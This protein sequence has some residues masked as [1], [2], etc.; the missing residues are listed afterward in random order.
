VNKVCRIFCFLL[1]FSDV[2]G[3]R[4]AVVEEIVV[5][6]VGVFCGGFCTN[7]VSFDVVLC[8]GIQVLC[9]LLCAGCVHGVSGIAILADDDMNVEG[10][11]I[12]LYLMG[13]P[14]DRGVDWDCLVRLVSQDEESGWFMAPTC[15][16]GSVPLRG[17]SSSGELG[18]LAEASD[19]WV[20]GD[21]ISS[22][23]STFSKHLGVDVLLKT[24][25]KIYFPLPG[26]RSASSYVLR[27]PAAT[28]TGRS[29]RGLVCNLLFF[30]G[31]PCKIW[32]VTADI[33]M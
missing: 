15:L 31:G 12:L 11:R 16:G 1:V 3:G 5:H 27:P 9:G 22:G 18:F 29:L 23:R 20:L 8:V 7:V 10:R 4:L 26:R 32:A 21:V 25:T 24:A 17:D 28:K 33:F 30:H 13:D 14:I 19:S 6:G 2:G